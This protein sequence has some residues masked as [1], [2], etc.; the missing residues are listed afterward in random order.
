MGCNMSKEEYIVINSNKWDYLEKLGSGSFG[1]VVK[2]KCDDYSYNSNS[3][4]GAIKIFK[5]KSNNYV[6]ENTNS[7]Y[8]KDMIYK[9]I[10][11]L[12]VLNH[13]NIIKFFGS[14]E[15]K[16]NIYILT[17]YVSGITLYK[18]VKD[19]CTSE[20]MN[21]KFIKEL[22]K[23]IGFIHKMG[24]IYVDLKLENII[25]KNGMLTDGFKLIDFGSIETIKNTHNYQ[26]RI[27]TK[28]YCAPEL[29]Y[30]NKISRSNDIWAIGVISFIL[31]HK[32]MPYHSKLYKKDIPYIRWPKLKFKNA[33]DNAIDFWKNVINTNINARYTINDM[34]MHPWLNNNQIIIN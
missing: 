20:E 2:A 8:H 11:A 4:F 17:E 34:L 27:I 15:T 7:S 28:G 10:E 21:I 24:F 23:T 31:H 6:Y 3:I 19:H 29:Y 33:S 9:E 16:N 25:V 32:Y 18:W 12:S 14:T 1:M 5:K 22:I 26:W 13:N 30:K